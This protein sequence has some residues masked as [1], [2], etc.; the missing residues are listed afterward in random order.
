MSSRINP[1]IYINKLLNLKGLSKVIIIHKTLKEAAE[2][3]TPNKIFI[4]FQNNLNYLALSLAHEYTHLIMRFNQWNG[5][6]NIK[7]LLRRYENF[8]G[9]KDR[10]KLEYSIEQA[11]AILAQTSYE[12]YAKISKLN[13]KR[14]QQLMKYMDAYA[15]GK[16]YLKKWRNYLKS[17]FDKKNIFNFIQK[18]LKTFKTN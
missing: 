1:I 18:G 14:I 5:E 17:N 2:F 13:Y 9:K 11:I 12:N 16:I 3:R 7:K 6:I 10:E 4:D 15:I 8:K